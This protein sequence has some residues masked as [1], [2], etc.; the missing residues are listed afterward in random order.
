MASS[1]TINDIN[2]NTAHG[3]NLPVI[4]TRENSCCI[5]FGACNQVI[6]ILDIPQWLQSLGGE[7]EL[8]RYSKIWIS[9][10]K[11]WGYSAR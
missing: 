4:W 7:V 8:D 3:T 6:H 10:E 11:G 2:I 1:C 5:Y 9:G